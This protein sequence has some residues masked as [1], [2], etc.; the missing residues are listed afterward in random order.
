MTS[1]LVSDVPVGVL[2]SGGLDSSIVAAVMQAQL[3]QPIKTFSV[4][5]ED[6]G[7]YDERPFARKVAQHL[8]TDHYDIGLTARDFVDALQS[9]MWHMDEPV[10]DPASIPL[11]YVS[12]LARQHVTVVLSGEGADELFAGYAF[13]TRFKG[14][15]RL[16]IFQKIP[17]ILRETIVRGAQR[18]RSAFRSR[19]SISRLKSVSLV[20]V[21]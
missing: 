9:Y 8:G 5:F 14:Q 12:Q 20:A 21:R 10:A 18:V 11:F 7:A 15:R 1:H 19:E 2:L 6:G 16:E 4:G 3:T 13:W 17:A